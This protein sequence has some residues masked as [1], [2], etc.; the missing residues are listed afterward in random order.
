MTAPCRT[1]PAHPG[2]CLTEGDPL[3]MPSHPRRIFQVRTARRIAS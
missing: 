3:A 1:P 2:V